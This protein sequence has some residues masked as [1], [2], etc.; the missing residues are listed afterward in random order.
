MVEIPRSPW[1]RAIGIPL[2]SVDWILMDLTGENGLRYELLTA[3]Q[4]F[5]EVLFI[6]LYS[7]WS[8]D[9]LALNLEL[10]ASF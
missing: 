4:A 10:L 8:G 3:F 7:A 1:L 6:G 9:E 2:L 5:L